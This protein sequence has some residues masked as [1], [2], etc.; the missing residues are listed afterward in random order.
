MTHPMGT[1][2][3][4]VTKSLFDRGLAR[5]TARP[6]PQ[7]SDGIVADAVIGAAVRETGASHRALAD[8][9]MEARITAVLSNVDAIRTRAKNVY[10]SVSDGVIRLYGAVRDSDAARDIENAIRTNAGTGT[11]QNEI[12]TVGARSGD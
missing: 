5:T 10:V 3:N 4:G 2:G 8:R 9:R 11:V 12:H 7:G 1:R 6:A